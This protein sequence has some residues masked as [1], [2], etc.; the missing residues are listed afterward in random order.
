[1]HGACRTGLTMAPLAVSRPT[2]YGN[3]HKPSRSAVS[4]SDGPPPGIWS[5]ARCLPG[6]SCIEDADAAAVVV[7]SGFEQVPGALGPEVAGGGE[8]LGGL[9]GFGQEAGDLGL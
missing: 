6:R 1:M 9:A 5:A 4:G 3:R 2:S 7:V 8:D